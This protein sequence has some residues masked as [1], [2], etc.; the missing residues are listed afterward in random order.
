MWSRLNKP[1]SGAQLQQQPID[2]RQVSRLSAAP[3][4]RWLQQIA[5]QA[6]RTCVFGKDSLLYKQ[7]TPY[8][9]Q[10]LGTLKRQGP[11][12]NNW[13]LVSL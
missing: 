9:L 4:A 10:H 8:L 7:S 13:G 6:D 3:P 2:R 12:T 5:V 1:S 11:E